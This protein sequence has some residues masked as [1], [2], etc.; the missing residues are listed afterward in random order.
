MGGP[1]WEPDTVCAAALLSDTG[2]WV[3]SREEGKNV[4]KDVLDPL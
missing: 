2:A 4:A 1:C 3:Q